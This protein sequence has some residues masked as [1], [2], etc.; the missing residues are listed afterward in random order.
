MNIAP[1]IPCQNK[2]Y[3]IYDKI[4]KQNSYLT[5][6]ELHILNTN[7]KTL[8]RLTT[9]PKHSEQNEW[10]EFNKVPRSLIVD[11]EHNE[12]IIA[13]WIERAKNKRSGQSTE[14]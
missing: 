4:N 2:Q 6:L 11:V 3:A 12:V 13:E 14:K 7:K 10:N 5:A 8:Q 1:H 9:Y